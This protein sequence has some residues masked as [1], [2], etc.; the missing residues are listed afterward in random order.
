MV[1]T[2]V[3]RYSKFK[4]RCSKGMKL[5]IRE[6]LWHLLGISK[7]HIQY[8]VDSRFLK[9]DPY[10]TKGFKTYDNNAVVYR[11][12]DT[13]LKIGKYCSISYGVKFVMDDGKHTY[14]QVTNYPFPTNEIGAKKGISIGNDVWIGLNA[15][16][17]NGVKIGNGVTIAA[18]AVVAKDVP[19]YCV[20]AG[21]PAKIIKRKCTEQDAKKMSQIA[22]WNWSEEQINKAMPDF[23]RSIS[24]FI[25]KYN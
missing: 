5:K 21:V 25:E 8:V 24:E 2:Q 4:I 12:S 15:I 17:L 9:E 14:N 3:G 10:T 1:L 20:A 16:I 13:P 23:K 22:W 6:F 18:G 11:W 19:D 7:Q